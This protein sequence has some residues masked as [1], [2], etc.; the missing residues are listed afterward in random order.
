MGEMAH[1][2]TAME[3]AA[4]MQVTPERVGQLFR[5]F[6]DGK[7]PHFAGRFNRFA[8]LSP[9][10]AAVLRG[11]DLELPATKIESE[12]V[13]H[14]A[15]NVSGNLDTGRSNEAA[16]KEFKRVQW[17]FKMP[18]IEAIAAWAMFLIPTLASIRNT[19]SV[20]GGLSGD[21]QTAMLLTA[22]ISGTGILWIVSRKKVSWGDMAGIFV[23]QLFEAFS[24]M[25][26][27]FKTLMGSMSYGITTVSG[28][29]SDLLDMVAVTTRSDHRD[30]AIILAIGV[31][32]FVLA[33]QVK[34]LLLIKN[35]KK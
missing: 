7:H 34:G 10:Q 18:T 9:I 14:V 33:A 25:V 21:Y 1:R 31:A 5:A 16:P 15:T 26:Q 11:E 24:N 8:E 3:L 30:T 13:A 23:F 28:T 4:E 27:V 19:V 22:T 6:R 17:R 32:L 29:P 2:I 35:L 20:S 12:S